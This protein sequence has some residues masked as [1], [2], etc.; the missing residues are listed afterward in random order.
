MNFKSHS[1]IGM[2]MASK[3]AASSLLTF[4]LG[5]GPAGYPTLKL[6]TRKKSFRKGLKLATTASATKPPA[7]RTRADFQIEFDFEFDLKITVNKHSKTNVKLVT[8]NIA[9][10]LSMQLTVIVST[11]LQSFENR[12]FSEIFEKSRTILV[13]CLGQG[14]FAKAQMRFPSEIWCPSES[15]LPSETQT[16]TDSKTCAKVKSEV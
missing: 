8:T 15:W 13:R 9:K 3:L 16:H 12:K 2:S 6:P 1:T 5:K 4:A 11:H 7:L 14:L 10:P